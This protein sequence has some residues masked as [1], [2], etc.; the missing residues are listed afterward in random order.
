M[1][2][3]KQLAEWNA[4]ADAATE[5]PWEA[6]P[7]HSSTTRCNGIRQGGFPGPESDEYDLEGFVVET[8]SGEYAPDMATARFIAAAR[9]AVPAL[10][11]EVGRLRDALHRYGA[12]TLMCPAPQSSGRQ[13]A[14]CTC[15]FE[16]ATGRAAKDP[17]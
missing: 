15:G 7:H 5:G 11:E 17:K 1:I 2:D 8:D 14:P 13:Q 3:D 10:V 6:L 16:S 9:T 4:L 12:H